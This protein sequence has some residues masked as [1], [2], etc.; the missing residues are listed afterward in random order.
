MPSRQERRKAER[1]AAKR[2]AGQAGAAGAANVNPGG[3]WRTQAENPD[4]LR[5]AL[6]DETVKRRAREGDREA[7]WSMGYYLVATAGVEGT[8][9]GSGGRS[10]TADVGLAL[11]TA[12][13]SGRLL[14][15]VD[16]VT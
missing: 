4:V 3:D 16:V 10:P 15:R 2:G 8:P 13:V 11:C 5:R 7:Q 12:K 6:G 14:R 1:E 9:L